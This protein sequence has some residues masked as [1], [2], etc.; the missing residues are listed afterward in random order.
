MSGHE[1][2]SK[3]VD[4]L[5]KY[6]HSETSTW[7]IYMEGASVLPNRPVHLV[8]VDYMRLNYKRLGNDSLLVIDVI[9]P[10]KPQIPMQ[11]IIRNDKW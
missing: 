7:I 4:Y 2:W 3:A 10:H 9:L 8:P 11:V 1:R 5:S 6:K